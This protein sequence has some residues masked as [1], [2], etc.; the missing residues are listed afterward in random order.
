MT[1]TTPLALAATAMIAILTTISSPAFA[2]PV[3]DSFP[4]WSIDPRLRVAKR[5]AG[6]ILVQP[7]R[8]TGLMSV[9]IPEPLVQ[10]TAAPY[11]LSTGASCAE[12]SAEIAGLSAVLGPDLIAEPGQ[13]ESRVGKLAEAGGRAAVN[14]LI[15][16]RLLVREV[17]GAAPAQRRFQ[18]AVELGYARR[19]F[20]RGIYR[21]RDCPAD[22]AAG[23]GPAPY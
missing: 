3:L 1:P 9:E 22:P 15:P 17:T 19:G 20:L 21:L 18:E 16:F 5:T 13:R 14:S 11:A 10:A 12:V 2:Q 7:I 6:D 4:A 23:I 8:D